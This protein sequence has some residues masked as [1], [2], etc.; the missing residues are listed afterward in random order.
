MSGYSEMYQEHQDSA[1]IQRWC[2]KWAANERREVRLA[3]AEGA[4]TADELKKL[5]ADLACLKRL[6]KA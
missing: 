1:T 3:L 6:V 4:K 2:P 5:R